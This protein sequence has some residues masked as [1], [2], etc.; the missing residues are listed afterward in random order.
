M[1]AYV[2][3]SITVARCAHEFARHEDGTAWFND[4][5][6]YPTLHKAWQEGGVA[7]VA[8][9]M[10]RLN[11]RAVNYRYGE[12]TP[13]NVALM[14]DKAK[15]HVRDDRLAGKVQRAKSLDCLLY[16]CSEG[17]VPNTKLYREIARLRDRLN[18]DIVGEVPEY[19]EAVW[20]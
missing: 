3:D 20:G 7:G 9:A 19:S 16:Q 10:A 17:K 5:E 18:A 6:S 1:S 11:V 8:V 2:C 12:R 4:G 14:I 15:L 13:V